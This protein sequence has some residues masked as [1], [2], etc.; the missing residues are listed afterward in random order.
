MCCGY[1]VKN[2][3]RR[4]KP[5]LF[6]ELLSRHGISMNINWNASPY[7]Y[8]RDVFMAYSLMDSN[9]KMN[10]EP[11][12]VEIGTFAS[13][14]GASEAIIRSL[15]SVSL[16]LP[17]EYAEE[18]VLNQAAWLYLE[19]P[20]IWTDID[21]YAPIDRVKKN[22]WFLADVERKLID[23]FPD[24]RNPDIKQ[25]E[26]ELSSYIQGHQGRGK[27]L[28]I[29]YQVRGDDEYYMIYL[30]DYNRFIT[31]CENG[32]FNHE[33]I[34]TKAAHLAFVYHRTTF[35]LEAFLPGFIRKEKVEMCNIWAQIV[36]NSYIVGAERTKY[37]YDLSPI[38]D[39]DFVFSTDDEGLL[40]SAMP[41]GIRVSVKGYPTSRQ[42]FMEKD[43]SIYKRMEEAIKNHIL[44]RDNRVVE[45]LDVRTILAKEFGRSRFQT[46][47]FTPDGHNILDLNSKVHKP[48][49]LNANH[50]FC[51]YD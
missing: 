25:L 48:L 35:Q 6:S 42:I 45:W 31:T 50:W 27:F 38:L 2:T 10:L 33:A 30:N 22:R 11:D 32:E 17:P 21:I 34:S 9:E 12:L 19:H 28:E 26:S 46:V 15:G 1:N 47:R 4:I 40:E 18:N 49:L 41:I 43:C 24:S 3:V 16:S 51:R 23:P 20:E 13:W 39:P 44:T 29:S 14:A 37:V 36:K 5:G 7:N 8:R